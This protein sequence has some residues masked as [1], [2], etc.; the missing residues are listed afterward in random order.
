MSQMNVSREIDL[1]QSHGPHLNV[2]FRRETRSI[3]T[4]KCRGILR[5][6]FS[7]HR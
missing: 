6:V 3:Q 1:I 7:R 5:L 2:M 4:I